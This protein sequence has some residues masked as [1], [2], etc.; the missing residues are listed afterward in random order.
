M[1]NSDLFQATFL[2]TAAV[3]VKQGKAIYINLFTRSSSW[4]SAAAS[5]NSH[6][7]GKDINIWI[8]KCI[9]RSKASGEKKFILL[10]QIMHLGGRKRKDAPT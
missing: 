1:S 5:K 2:F 8:Y 10:F 6:R 7:I 4:Y 9:D 3:D